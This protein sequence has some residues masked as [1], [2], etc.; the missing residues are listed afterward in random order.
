MASPTPLKPIKSYL[1][2]FKPVP[3]GKEPARYTVALSQSGPPTLYSAT[4]IALNT[5]SPTP[6][7]NGGLTHWHLSSLE[8][9]DSLCA[10]VDNQLMA[11]NP[12]KEPQ[13]SKERF[14]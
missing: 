9:L 13:Y 3:P 5:D 11:L 6:Q 8:S 1:V 10:D 7:D 14:L 4:V 2:W 12:A